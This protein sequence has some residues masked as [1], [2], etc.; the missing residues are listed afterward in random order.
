M[1]SHKF[2]RFELVLDKIEVGCYCVCTSILVAPRRKPSLI[3]TI[4]RTESWPDLGA[5]WPAMESS[6][7]REQRGRRRGCGLA[8]G[9]GALG[10]MQRRGGRG[11]MGSASISQVRHVLLCV[12]ERR[13][14]RGER[15]EKLE[16]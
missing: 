12:P 4:Y 16:K 11:A 7:E 15:K 9:E 13:K 8:I 1:K 14:G 10:G 3:E 2:W 5:Q 6:P